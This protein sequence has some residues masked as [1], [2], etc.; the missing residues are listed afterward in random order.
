MKHTIGLPFNLSV[1]VQRN[2]IGI[3]LF[4]SGGSYINDSRPSTVIYTPE[5]HSDFLNSQIEI[6][7]DAALL[8]SLQML[9]NC[10]SD[11]AVMTLICLS[12]A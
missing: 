8:L 9:T 1:D 12:F 7:R 10:H 11:T 3:Y 6:V 4:D 5:I 2:L